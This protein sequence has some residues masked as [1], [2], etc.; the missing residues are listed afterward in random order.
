MLGI[1]ISVFIFGF[2][3]LFSGNYIHTKYYKFT[4]LFPLLLFVYFSYF[5]YPIHWEQEIIISYKWIPSL[6][7]NFDFKIDGL[8]LLF[9]LLITGIG[10]LIYFYA[11][12]YL[13]KYPYLS[14]FYCYL[15]LFMGAMLGLVLSDNL[16]TIFMFWEL[17]SITSFFLIGFNNEDESSRKSA[18]T[19][20]G[21]TGLGGFLLLSGFLIIANI[22]GTF[23][24]NE[25][26]NS[27]ELIQNHSWFP[28]ILV[29]IF[30]GAFTKSA[31]FP[32]H[33]WL[34]GAMQAPT[35]VS[36]Y[37]HSATMVKAGIYILARLT[38]VLSD[39]FIWNYTLMIVGGM[40]MFF[41]AFHSIFRS[42]MKSVLAYSTISALGIIVFLLG[43]G[44]EYA[45]YAAMTFI[46]VH[47][48]Y[49]ATL[50]LVTG[51]VD[52]T[53]H[54][55]D[56]SQ[57]Y[58]LGKI[59]PVVAIASAVAALSSAG[60]PLTFGFISKDLIYES[61]L[62][63]PKWG[64]YL[65]I[66]AV[67]TNVLLACSGFIVGIKP[68][69]GKRAETETEIKK[70]KIYLWL[71]VVILSTL[72]LLFGIFP[73]IADKGILTFAFQS[74]NAKPSGL[75]L[76]I[77]HGFNFVLLLSG[78]TIVLGLILF[79][80]NKYF[81]KAENSIEKFNK[82]S[83]QNI[84]EFLGDKFRIFAFI[85]TRF[86]HNGYLRNY[87]IM[88]ILFITLLVGYR[89]F[90]TTPIRINTDDL[91]GLRMYEITIF[92]IIVVS[93]YFTLRTTSRLT[94]IAGMGVIG[95]GICLIF[96]F[97]GAP[98][99]AMTQF[100]IDTLTVVLFV[101]VLFKLPSFLTFR[102]RKI[103]LRDASISIGFGALIMIITLQ[104][105]ISP[106]DMEVS[107]FYAENAYKLAKG[108]NVVNVILVDF[109]GFDTLIETIVLSIAALGVYGLLKYRGINEEA[110]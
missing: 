101:L 32:F 41:G 88:M 83:P 44:N 23:S 46:L 1:L 14:R 9:A 64:M 91:T 20:L 97:Y 61:T 30:A 58:G 77:W 93:I 27:S 5:L 62:H 37:L 76:K 63:F 18:L 60:I 40:T 110:D 16:I 105:L 7:V 47:A 73:F 100:T 107:N 8:S 49:K 38:P 39:G 69:L 89:L 15:T 11:S 13:K 17:T 57:V 104:A 90:T 96:V 68:F 66:F 102:S 36:A 4:A 55:R 53:L 19:A 78:I 22:T 108:K 80:F 85:Y 12:Y 109:R 79:L 103:Q 99:L 42:D 82:V 28:L 25:L 10:S 24:I 35:P 65:T 81:R 54:T 94:A 34:P 6:G 45:L 95:Y 33:F 75:Y 92:V 29:F 43:L 86:L 31:Q 26:L 3:I 98:D 70:P 67:A 87:I 51:I 2:L 56:L 84:V 71:P 59:M 106:A 50:F 52:H 48:L 72:T 74:V 21:V